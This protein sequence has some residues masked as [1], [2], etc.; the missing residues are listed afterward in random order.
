[1]IG[2]WYLYQTTYYP[3][4]H[5]CTNRCETLFEWTTHKRHVPKQWRDYPVEWREP[6]LAAAMLEGALD[7][8]HSLLDAH[9]AA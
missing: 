7:E 8:R 4:W 3:W 1:M 9:D 5:E 6:L 2:A